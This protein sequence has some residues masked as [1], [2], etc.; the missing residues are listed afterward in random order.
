LNSAA[1]AFGA[2]LFVLRRPGAVG[3]VCPPAI[4][5][6]ANAPHPPDALALL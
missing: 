6:G 5:A 2:A 1:P 4:L 3:G